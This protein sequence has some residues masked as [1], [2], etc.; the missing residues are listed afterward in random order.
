MMT[1]QFS[2]LFGPDFKAEIKPLMEKWQIPTAAI[3]Y[4]IDGQEPVYNI[5]QS[6]SLPNGGITPQVWTVCL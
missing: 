2:D 6:N 3:V 4:I 1:N 5:V